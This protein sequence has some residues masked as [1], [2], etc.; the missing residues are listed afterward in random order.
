MIQKADLNSPRERV[1]LHMPNTIVHFEIPADDA[2]R[3]SR[4]YSDAFGWKFEKAKMPGPE[5][6]L[7]STGLRGKSVGGGMYKKADMPGARPVNYV[8]IDNIDSAIERFKRAGGTV[9]IGKQEVPGT[10]WS[11]IGTDPE[12]NPIALWQAMKPARR[13]PRSQRSR[14]AKRRR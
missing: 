10:G 6:W 3:L 12:G 7:I 13:A 4:F 1:N 9:V 14:K 2:E 11:L 8:G 5:Y